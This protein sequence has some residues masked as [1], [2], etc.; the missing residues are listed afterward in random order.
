[1]VKEEQISKIE[2]KNAGLWSTL[3]DKLTPGGSAIK[4]PKK[5]CSCYVLITCTEPSGD[6]DMEVEMTYEGEESLVAYL[7]ENAQVFFQ[8]D[9]SSET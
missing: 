2:S 9:S 7:V 3:K 8:K 5:N 1:V 6:G 4:K